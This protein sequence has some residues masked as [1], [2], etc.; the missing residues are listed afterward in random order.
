MIL[1]CAKILD[2][3][4][5]FFNSCLGKAHSQLCWSWQLEENNPNLNSGMPLGS[6]MFG[7]E[8]AALPHGATLLNSRSRIYTF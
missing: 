8:S 4:L 3:T 5:G 1:K 6:S 7:Q 2:T